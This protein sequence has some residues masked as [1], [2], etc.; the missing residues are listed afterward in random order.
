MGRAQGARN[1]SQQKNQHPFSEKNKRTRLNVGP[2]SFQ[3]MN[4]ARA[5]RAKL[6]IAKKTNTFLEKNE[7][8]RLNV[9][10]RCFQPMNR[11]R[12]GRAKLFIAKNPTPFFGKK[13]E[14]QTKC[15]TKKFLAYERGARRERG[16]VYS[17]KKT[18]PFLEK[19]RELD[20][21]QDQEVFSL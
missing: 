11:A 7:R 4:W 10:Q 8:T 15:R 17:K 5:G 9:G 14:N 12:A 13:L 21:M 16:T 19:M 2:R 3:P 18:T 6:F 20:Q 1:C